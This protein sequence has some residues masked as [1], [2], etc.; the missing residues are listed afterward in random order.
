MLNRKEDCC[1]NL[2]YGRTKQSSFLFKIRA[3][4]ISVNN[5]SS[6][7][8]KLYFQNKSVSALCQGLEFSLWFLQQSHLLYRW[9]MSTPHSNAPDAD[10]IVYPA[11]SHFPTDTDLCHS[12]CPSGNLLFSDSSNFFLSSGNTWIFSVS[13]LSSLHIR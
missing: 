8:L 4:S 3:P 2:P 1:F 5:I 7:Y 12:A 11:S 9:E 13:L 6:Q 10:G